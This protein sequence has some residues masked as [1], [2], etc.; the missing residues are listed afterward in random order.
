[1]RRI[2]A[3]SSPL[4]RRRLRNFRANRRG[5]W[6]LWIF[7][8]LFVRQ[9][10]RRADRQRPA[11]AS[12]ATTARFYV[13]VLVAYPETTF[14]G[15]FPTETDYRDP[16]VIKL[17]EAKGWML[18][19]PIPFRYDTINYDLPVPAPAAAVAGQ[20]ARH[21]RPGARP[22]GPA[23]LRL[24]H[25]RALRARAHPRSA[26][27]S[28]SPPAPCRATSAA[29]PTSLFQRFIEVW[30]GLPVL[31]LLIILASIVEPNFWW[32]LR[33]DAALQLDGAGGR[34]ARRVPARPQLRLRAGRARPRRRATR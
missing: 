34:G 26:R 19:P 9:P 29:G 12:S 23:D 21:R 32:L 17:I 6:S 14:G 18:W 4:T 8:V 3:A 33:P 11:A 2:A 5:F 30:S 25:L 27:S 15:T 28:A 13:P 16:A 10:R 24:S 20:L 22:A 31:Y 7:L 1:M